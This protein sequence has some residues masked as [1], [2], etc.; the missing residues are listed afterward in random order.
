[1]A[2]DENSDENS[3]ENA[4]K[5]TRPAT[6]R[7]LLPLPLGSGYDYQVPEG[8]D[9]APGDFVTVPLSRRRVNGVVWDDDGGDCQVAPERLKPVVARLDV[10][11]LTAVHRRFIDWV[12]K[13]TLSAPGSV[14]RM[15]M[16]VPG[17]LEPPRPRT[18]YVVDGPPPKRL[19]AARSR[20]LAVLADGPPR[21]LGDLAREAATG[22]SV[23]R[24]LV[25][26]GP[27]RAIALADRPVAEIPDWHREG[28]RL[29][30]DQ[31][32]AAA[33]LWDR[34]EEGGFSVTVLDGV[35]GAGKT[36]VYFEAIAAALKSG[37]QALVLLP[38]IS[39]TAQWLGR[40]TS[41]FGAPPAQWH[42]ELGQ[43]R[44]R[45]VWRAVAENRV[46]VVVGARS[47][48]FLPFQDLRLIVVDEEHEGS[49]KQEDGVIYHARDMAVVRASLGQIPALLVSATPSLESLVNAADG[50]YRLS[51]LP[52]RH[53]AA[54]LPEISAV[55]MRSQGPAAGHWISP[56][57]AASVE[58]ALGAGEQAL[59]FLNRRG[60][61]PLTLCRHCGHRFDCPHCS[62]WLVEHRFK[63]QLMC[64]HCGHSVRLPEL[65]PKCEAEG[66][67]V[68]CGPG[69]ERLG[70]EVAERFPGAR[71]AVFSSDTM[72][73]PGAAAEF[74]RR[75][76]EREIDLLIGTQILAKGLHFPLLTV[77]GVI[78]ADLGLAGGDLRAAERT[79]QLLSQVAGRAGRAEH[80]G[81]V[82]LQTYMPEH[83][84]MQSLLSGDRQQFIDTETAARRASGMPPFGRL[85]AVIVSAP[86][87][88]TAAAVARELGR[89]A[90][91]AAG[92]EVLGP[93]PAPLALLRGKYRFRLLLK[94]RRE[95]DVP[96]AVR[97]WL[98][99]VKVPRRVRV[100]ADIDPY[101]F[102]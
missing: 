53:G 63:R 93:A 67:L 37:G 100:R 11:P 98:A 30:P 92:I 52:E 41:R 43:A 46:A 80:P 28:P 18:A 48:L 69:V 21:S 12:S 56:P 47:A 25:A 31:A 102:L 86:D 27:L 87:E 99:S 55:D 8:L 57:L 62:A 9:L 2:A 59:L 91:R 45:R 40:F 14:L 13:Y 74:V 72:T 64:H 51:H 54:R 20:V 84:V 77:V 79:Y 89:V 70:E 95:V 83:P 76:E 101:S 15:A 36:E 33:D 23:V 97:R 94:A 61:A 16:S 68:A 4:G 26:A 50:R 35:T 75:V 39:L 49:F 60:Y 90:P 1:M 78:D 29:S 42:S 82:W 81:R 10:P 66:T 44:R 7:V 24:G 32:S 96:R 88:N 3:G 85:A 65:C 71:T 22:P 34:L 5:K 17:A 6:V 73:G 19:T 38:E 58:A